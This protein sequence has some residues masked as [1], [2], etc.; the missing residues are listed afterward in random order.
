MDRETLV[1]IIKQLSQTDVT[2]TV[3]RT[4]YPA[5][6]PSLPT[7]SQ[8]G[9]TVVITGGGTGVGLAIALNFIRA[10][11]DT[12][13]I[14]GRREDVLAAAASR[15]KQEVRTVGTSSTIIARTCDI[16]KLDE[17]GTFW[18]DLKA[19]NI[20]VDVLVN[21][22]AKFTEPKPLLALGADE[23]WSQIEANVK[24]PLYFNERFCAQSVG[25]QQV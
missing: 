5:I 12:V 6:S 3:H 10:S 17:I 2:K 24:A 16:T 20:T 21:N 15:L 7:L 8:A 9:R 14:V 18:N 1:Q 13:I 11:A 22:A 19:Q 25:R 23:V 4:A